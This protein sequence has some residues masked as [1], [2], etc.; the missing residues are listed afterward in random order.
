MDRMHPRDAASELTRVGIAGGSGSGKSTLTRALIARC[1]PAR[2]L[3][4]EHDAYYR[5][6]PGLS[7]A[8][9][10]ELNYD[11]PAALETS[12]LVAHL[13]ALGRGLEI[14]VPRYDFATHRR[15]SER[16]RL[17]ARPIVFVEGILCL[18][19]PEL[20]TR[21]DLAVFI[22]AN[23]AT[24]FARRQERD[25]GERAR[26]LA[27][28]VRQQRETVQPMHRKYVEP[29]RR[30]A[31][32]VVSGEGPLETAVEPVLARLRKLRGDLELS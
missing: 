29:S 24:R 20:R 30:F 4:L 16:L 7:L 10:Q 28:V 25:L 31:D 22:E 26:S 15:R 8:E 21:L 12:L 1:G 2:S 3:L 9:R 27:S 6:R 11:H 14:D 17:D 23:E 32:L 13:D 18:A 5:D 19:E